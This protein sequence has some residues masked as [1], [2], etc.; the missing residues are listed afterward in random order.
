ME[1][2]ELTVEACLD[3]LKANEG[4]PMSQI[5]PMKNDCRSYQLQSAYRFAVVIIPCHALGAPT[6]CHTHQPSWKAPQE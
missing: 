2:S 3:A 6:I 5:L 1:Q 4:H